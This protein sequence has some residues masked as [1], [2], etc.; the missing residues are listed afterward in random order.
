MDREGILME[1]FQNEKPIHPQSTLRRSLE[2]PS[3]DDG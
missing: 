3:E 1:Q 2:Q